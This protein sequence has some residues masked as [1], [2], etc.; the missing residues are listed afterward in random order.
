MEH[1][2]VIEVLTHSCARWEK[3]KKIGLIDSS[4]KDV[5][6]F[7]ALMVCLGWA[8]CF[9]TQF[10]PSDSF[11]LLVAALEMWGWK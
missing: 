1:R 7:Q 11:P 9:P 5:L 8:P 3:K 10:L 2:A 4:R 6:T